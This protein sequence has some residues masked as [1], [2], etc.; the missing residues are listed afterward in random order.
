MPNLRHYGDLPP[1]TVQIHEADILAG[2]TDAARLGLEE[3]KQEADYRR[4]AGSGSLA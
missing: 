1:Q 2:D 3:T 4:L